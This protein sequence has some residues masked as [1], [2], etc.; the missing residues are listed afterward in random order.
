M[1][2]QNINNSILEKI[3]NIPKGYKH[4][5]TAT[6]LALMLTFSSCGEKEKETPKQLGDFELVDKQN[7]G[8][9]TWN[10]YKYTIKKGEYPLLVARNFNIIDKENSDIFVETGSR[11]I[12]DKNQNE[13]KS[14]QKF[15]IGETLYIKVQKYKKK[16]SD[17]NYNFSKPDNY[18]YRSKNEKGSGVVT[19]EKEIIIDGKKEKIT[20]KQDAGLTFYVVQKDDFFVNTIVSDG[21]KINHCIDFDKIISKLSQI[22]EFSYLTDPIYQRTEQVGKNE[23]KFK[24]KLFSF[25][26]NPIDIAKISK[27][28]IENGKFFI[29]IPTP[30]SE[31]IMEIQDFAYYA[32]QAIKEMENHPYYGPIVKDLL[33]TATR[34]EFLEALLAFAY[35]ESSSYGENNIGEFELHR[36]EGGKNQSFSFSYFHILMTPGHPGFKARIN[37]KM[38]EGESYHPK[39]ATKLFIAFRA[40]KVAEKG[41]KLSDYFP[42]D[43]N[44]YEKV[45]K[46]YNGGD[47]KKY[48]YHNKLKY[49]HER[50]KIFIKQNKKRK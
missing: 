26:I 42:L 29:P 16:E 48:D 40:E 17:Y 36:R 37:L 5:I 50:T 34:E 18:K 49:N 23:I 27:S 33:R 8:G 9:E 10:I 46:R 28:A 7:K 2:K 19:I 15:Q 32:Q 43:Y 41:Q 25:N 13:I 39:N 4:L 24:N 11:N 20:L 3:R 21:I 38:T 35:N 47:Y 14:D 44:T 6:S 12:L 45:A 31:R 30:K 22:D 1:N